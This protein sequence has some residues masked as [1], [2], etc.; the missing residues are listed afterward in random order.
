MVR[1]EDE[2]A[3]GREDVMNEE[4]VKSRDDE[5]HQKELYRVKAEGVG[6]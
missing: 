1:V 4:V 2:C 3:T 5:G 6:E